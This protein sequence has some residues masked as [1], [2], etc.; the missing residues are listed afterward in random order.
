V[1]WTVAEPPGPAL[2]WSQEEKEKCVAAAN[3]VIADGGSDQDAI[4]ACIHAAGRS[5]RSMPSDDMQ[6]AFGGTIKAVGDG[7]VQGYLVRWGSEKDRDLDDE[8]FTKDTFFG[9]RRGDRSD[10]FL[11]HGIPIDEAVKDYAPRTMKNPVTVKEDEVG[12]LATHLLDMA[13]EYEHMIHGL[14]E[15]EKLCWSSGAIPYGVVVEKNG[16]IKRWPIVEASYTP[17][18]AEPRNH[19]MALKAYLEAGKPE[20]RVPEGGAPASPAPVEATTEPEAKSSVATSAQRRTKTSRRTDKMKIVKANGQYF[21]MNV[22]EEGEPTGLP[23]KTFDDETAANDYL[24]ESARPAWERA[25]TSMSKALEELPTQVSMAVKGAVQTPTE[26]DY[27][28]SKGSGPATV[29]TG[30]TMLE[31]TK[32]LVANDRVALA[33]MGSKLKSTKDID[34]RTGPS[35]AYTVPEPSAREF[36]QLDPESEVVWPRARI[37]D[38]S[39]GGTLQIPGLDHSGSTAAQSNFFGGFLGEWNEHGTNKPETEPT[40]VQIKLDAN[41]FAA[42]TEV[43]ENV[44]RH[45]ILN[46]A[47][48]L[49]SLGRANCMFYTDEAFLDG[50]GVGQPLGIINAGATITVAR[51]GAGA[52]VYADLVNMLSDMLPGSMGNAVWIIQHSVLPELLTMVDPLGAYVWQPNARDGINWPLFGRPIIWTEKTP[53]LGTAGDVILADLRYY[54]IGRDQDVYVARSDDYLF[55]SN[56]VAFKVVIQVDGQPALENAIYLKDGATQ[57]SPFVILGD[58]ST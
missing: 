13:D 3:A 2:N 22:D 49:S 26:H 50:T 7:L 43:S 23:V 35:G 48:W 31:F 19:I 10:V 5:E 53:T 38:I 45:S 46:L 9:A 29:K 52:V 42:Y 36:F 41:E 1:P 15:A 12:L 58:A 51:T 44:L 57:V 30:P 8:F 37:W 25:I 28:I 55:R 14:V 24:T 11:H 39:E 47:T 27:Y 21:V 32:A 20:G 40:F 4:F 54:Y 17:T 56:K 34:E 33:N 18:P 16:H 6:I